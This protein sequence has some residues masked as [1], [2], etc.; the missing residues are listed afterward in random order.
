MTEV[1]DR[2]QAAELHASDSGSVNDVSTA[3]H[4]RLLCEARKTKIATTTRHL[5][6]SHPKKKANARNGVL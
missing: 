1:P 4:A 2:V 3:S 5:H 6:N